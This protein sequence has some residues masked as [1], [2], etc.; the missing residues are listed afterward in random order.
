MQNQPALD[1]PQDVQLPQVLLTTVVFL[2]TQIFGLILSVILCFTLNDF[3]WGFFR[4]S[5]LNSFL[6]GSALVGVGAI[7]RR[8][9]GHMR[10]VPIGL[11]TFLMLGGVAIAS[12]VLLLV[13]EPALFLYYGR[14]AVSFLI[15]NF[16]FIV[17]LHII[18]TGFVSSRHTLQAKEISLL[19]ERQLRSEIEMQM[20]SARVNPHFLFNTLNMILSLLPDP[21]KAERA[22][23]NLADLLRE[24][25]HRSQKPQIGLQEELDNVE[26]YLQIQQMRFGDKFSYAIEGTAA[27]A[28]PPLI[29][30]PLVENS[31][32]HCMQ[33]VESLHIDIQISQQGS[34]VT[35]I[36]KD[37]VGAVEPSMVGRGQGLTLTRKR[38]EAAK[39]TFS[40][41]DGGIVISFPG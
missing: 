9:L 15:I 22:L 40:I 16:L 28:L 1:T 23:L 19:R 4:M 24:N 5:L 31:I 18:T 26:K 25:L 30:Q 17:I 29:L 36:I 41:T 11:L 39:G 13:R 38:V 3:I 33:Q 12:L 21:H 34:A 32:K 2:V 14:G 6:L 20:L 27:L 8:L 7:T 37:S 35:L 10:I